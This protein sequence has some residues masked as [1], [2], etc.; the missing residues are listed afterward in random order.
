[1]RYEYRLV[2]TITEA[3]DKIDS[4]REEAG[5]FVLLTN[6]LDQQAEWSAEALLSLYKSQIGIEK[7]FS[8]LKKARRIEVL[9]LILLISLLIWRLMERSM[10]QYVEANDCE[11]PGWDVGDGD[12]F[13]R[14]SFLNPFYFKKTRRGPGHSSKCM[15][16]VL[17]IILPHIPRIQPQRLTFPLNPLSQ[18]HSR[19]F[20]IRINTECC[21][22]HFLQF[23]GEQTEQADSGSIGLLVS[24]PPM[25]RPF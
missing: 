7:N 19:L 10:R 6:L 14:F 5:C 9:E 3:S 20:R 11:L 1:M 21:T 18:D 2:T 23:L 13:M 12:V 17:T 22:D 24:F 25:I 8:F 15:D 4:L 16:L